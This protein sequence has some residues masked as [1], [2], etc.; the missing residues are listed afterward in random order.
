MRNQKDDNQLRNQK[1]EEEDEISE[2]S[3]ID[4]LAEFIG[5]KLGPILQIPPILPAIIFLNHNYHSKGTQ[6]THTRK[7]DKSRVTKVKEILSFGF[8]LEECKGNGI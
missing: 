1:D 3:L 6:Y 7:N 5:R 4:N 8:S 2:I